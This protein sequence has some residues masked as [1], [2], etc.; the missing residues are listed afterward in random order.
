MNSHI[1]DKEPPSNSAKKET[2]VSVSTPTPFLSPAP[3]I[4]MFMIKGRLKSPS[5]VRY[6]VTWN[7]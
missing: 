3:Q 7:K 6:V 1:P 2:P 5:K 4:S